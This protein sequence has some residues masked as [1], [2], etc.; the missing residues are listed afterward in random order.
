M[1]LLKTRRWDPMA[2]PFGHAL[3]DFWRAPLDE[4]I[5]FMPPMDLREVDDAFVLNAEL[6]GMK[7]EDITV[8]CEAGVLRISGEKK[9]EAVQKK[10][11]YYRAERR[12]GR[13][14]RE[15]FLGKEADVDLAEAQFKDGVLSIR[16]P[17]KESA[18]P[19]RIELN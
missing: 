14:T 2:F 16:L 5:E 10:G 12:F 15:F 9:L 18:K 19:K 4:S 8:S 3:K 13:F 6:P 7:K 11:D 17:K 1:E